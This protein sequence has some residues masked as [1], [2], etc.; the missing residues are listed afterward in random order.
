[1]RLKYLG[2][3]FLTLVFMIGTLR[4]GRRLGSPALM[5]LPIGAEGFRVLV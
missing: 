3:G 5:S 4:S 2:R 1:M